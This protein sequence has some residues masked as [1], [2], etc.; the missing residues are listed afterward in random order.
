MKSRVIVSALILIVVL[1]SFF[2][3]GREKG[4]KDAVVQG[5]QNGVPSEN[6]DTSFSRTQT[7]QAGA[8]DIEA[9]PVQ[10]ELGKEVIIELSLNT[11]SVELD[12]DYA[13]ISYLEDNNGNKYKALKWSGEK[14]GHHLG[15]MLTFEKLEENAQIV[16]LMISGI[17]NKDVFFEW[18]L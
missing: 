10:L 1:G 13:E 8:V 14:G 15:G 16:T 5:V 18:E 11:H 9:T 7:K 2:L 12:F 17:E 6:E 3:N 4:I